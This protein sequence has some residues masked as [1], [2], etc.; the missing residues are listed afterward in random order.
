ML[1]R[2]IDFS[3]RG[4]RLRVR[5][6]QLLITPDG[7]DE[8]SVPLAEIAV[9][10]AAHPQVAFTQA[11]LGGLASAGGIFIVCDERRLPAGMLLPLVRPSLTNPAVSRT[12]GCVRAHQETPL[13]TN[14]PRQDQNAGAGIGNA[15]RQ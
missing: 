7:G 4:A 11:V 1:P 10:I 8:C 14:R 9:L 5:F 2:I 6:N 15:T 12:S 13:A 3:D